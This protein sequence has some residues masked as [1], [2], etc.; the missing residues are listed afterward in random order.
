M[1]N[2]AFYRGRKRATTKFNFSF[3]TWIWSLETPGGFAYIW[4]SKWVGIIAI[5]AERTQIHFLSNV[6]TAFASLDL[7]VPNEG[8][9]LVPVFAIATHTDQIAFS[10]STKQP[11]VD[12]GKYD[13]A[14]WSL[15]QGDEEVDKLNKTKIYI[16][17]QIVQ[18]FGLKTNLL[19]GLN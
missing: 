14:N 19:Q 11:T 6:L 13:K 8:K 2:F 3:C 9:L 4:Q 1:P 5:R 12:A 18:Y 15:R 7:K 17:K 10:V 16:F